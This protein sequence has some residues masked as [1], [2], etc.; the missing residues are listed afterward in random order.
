MKNN[1]DIPDKLYFRIGEV[2]KIIGVDAHVLRYW[3]AEM[4]L[5]PHRSN[6]GQRLYRKVDITEFL[7]I[8]RLVHDEGYTISGARNI[9]QKERKGNDS[10]EIEHLEGILEKLMSLKNNL[11]TLKKDINEGS[12]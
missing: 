4:D 6:S 9:L 1:Q 3:E 7:R 10:V 2:S 12:L 11:D 8:K 5:K